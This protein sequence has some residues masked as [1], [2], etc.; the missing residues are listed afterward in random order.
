MLGERIKELR[1]ANRLSQV[2]L[3][4]ALNVTKQS[5]SNWEN[6]NIQPSVE[7]VKQIAVFFHCSVILS[8]EF[9]VDISDHGDLAL[10]DH[11]AFVCVLKRAY[12]PVLI[13]VYR[14]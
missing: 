3:A 10:R 4:S 11:A 7:L 5:V 1:L 8:F 2:E 6:D 9:V 14:K 12:R 13:C